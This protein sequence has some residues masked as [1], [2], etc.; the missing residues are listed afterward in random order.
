MKNDLL[1]VTSFIDISRYTNNFDESRK[2]TNLLENAKKTLPYLGDTLVYTTSDYFEFFD[3]FKNVRVAE[4]T[5]SDFEKRLKIYKSCNRRIGC[6]YIRESD[7]LVSMK[8]DF[9]LKSMCVSPHSH[10]RWSDLGLYKITKFNKNREYVMKFLDP[11]VTNLNDKIN[12]FRLNGGCCLPSY[13]CDSVDNALSKFS[14]HTAGGLI[15]GPKQLMTELCS[16]VLQSMLDSATMRKVSCHDE[17]FVAMFL[18][19]KLYD[20]CDMFDF[21]PSDHLYM[22]NSL[23]GRV[24]ISDQLISTV[25]EILTN[26]SEIEKLIYKRCMDKYGLTTFFESYD[27]YNNVKNT[28]SNLYSRSISAYKRKDTIDG[29]NCSKSIISILQSNDFVS[30]TNAL[31]N[32]KFY[33]KCSSTHDNGIIFESSINNDK[34]TVLYDNG[35]YNVYNGVQTYR[36]D[37]VLSC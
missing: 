6:E 9:M 10:I 25:K 7:A 1:T 11:G 36:F 33:T 37:P 3:Q 34:Y 27:K 4:F 23:F 20:G 12:V 15:W 30:Y 24:N 14:Y 35:N 19:R 18:S 13:S 29:Y 17:P 31:H 5:Y 21:M 8:Y 28:L 32:M 2:P 22:I 16:S 26:G